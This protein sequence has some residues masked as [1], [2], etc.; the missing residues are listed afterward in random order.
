M[1]YTEVG[2]EDEHRTCRLIELVCMLVLLIVVT[3]LVL[4]SDRQKKQIVRLELDKAEIT[5]H[6]NQVYRAL[7]DLDYQVNVITTEVLK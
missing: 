1:S 4:E 7:K 3:V 5:Q 2:N 6:L